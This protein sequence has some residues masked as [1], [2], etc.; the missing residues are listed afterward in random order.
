MV[1]ESSAF[2]FRIHLTVI[3]LS[4]F[5][6]H[7]SVAVSPRFTEI[8]LDGAAKNGEAKSIRVDDK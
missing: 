6:L 3:G 1:V 7:C 5:T 2:P 4:P 8:V